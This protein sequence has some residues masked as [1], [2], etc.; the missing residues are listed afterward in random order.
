MVE[1]LTALFMG[2]VFVF[3]I[4]F[5]FL[6]IARLAF[7]HV[8]RIARA[9][10]NSWNPGYMRI[11]FVKK[12][13]KTALFREHVQF[14]TGTAASA[15]AAMDVGV[16][17]L[18]LFTVDHMAL[19]EKSAG[20][21]LF[22]ISKTFTNAILAVVCVSIIIRFRRY[23]QNR[24]RTVAVINGVW[25]LFLLLI[26]L[27]SGFFSSN[28]NNLTLLKYVRLVHVF[29]GDCCIALVP[30]SRIGYWLISPLVNIT[31]HLGMRLLPN[32]PKRD[33]TA[34]YFKRLSEKRR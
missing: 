6:G 2:P 24:K 14:A 5:A 23:F 8:H 30:F 34:E 26:L 1:A 4:A 12:F 31:S 9:L 28:V 3:S 13:V 32:A 7:L 27:L 21:D 29:S 19:L 18:L 16:V 22:A 33:E 10:Y 11:D 20:V 15:W 25:F 17:F